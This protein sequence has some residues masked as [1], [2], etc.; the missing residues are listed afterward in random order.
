MREKY[1]TTDIYLTDNTL[2]KFPKNYSP[3]IEDLQKILDSS[4]R[5]KLIRDLASAANVKPYISSEGRPKLI[6]GGS[7]SG[8]DKYHSIRGKSNHDGSRGFRIGKTY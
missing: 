2:Y 6:K 1:D 3:K 8:S 7:L 5:D 4:R